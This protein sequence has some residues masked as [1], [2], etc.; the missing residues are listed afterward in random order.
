MITLR[1][2]Q[3]LLKKFKI[4]GPTESGKP[5]NILGD[6]YANIVYSRKG[7]FIVCVS[8]RSLLPIVLSARDLNRFVPRFKDLISEVL[9]ELGVPNKSVENEIIQMFPFFYGRTKNKIILGT[10]TDFTKDLKFMLLQN[11]Y[12]ELEWSLYFA[13]TP[14]GPL[15]YKNPI[16]VT[17]KL[18]EV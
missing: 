16:E 15:N 2:T 14:C 9:L 7:H 1:C 5:T 3:K 13:E 11:D 10:L 12:S 8:E 17:K 6:W 18:Y 4:D